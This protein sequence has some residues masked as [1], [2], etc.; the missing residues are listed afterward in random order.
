MCSSD[1]PV[2]YETGL[3][4]YKQDVLGK[5]YNASCLGTFSSKNSMDH[6]R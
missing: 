2:E 1:I 4:V 3:N 5:I 6:C